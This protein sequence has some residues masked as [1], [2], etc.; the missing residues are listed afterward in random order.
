MTGQQP[1]VGRDE[2][3]VAHEALIRHW[4]RLRAW[5]ET[6]RADLLLRESVRE[7]AQAWE[8]HDRDESYLLHRGRRLEETAALRAHPR[9]ELNAQERAYLDASIALRERERLAAEKAR[10]A[11]ERLLMG[12]SAVA[13]FLATVAGWQGWAAVQE[14]NN[15]EVQRVAA[16]EAAGTAEAE[17]D[18]AQIVAS[19]LLA[20]RAGSQ[21]IAPDLALLLSV[22]ALRSAETYEAKKAL[23][24]E[25]LENGP[26][27]ATSRMQGDPVTS[28]AF[29]ADGS[30][31]VW[32][33]EDGR[34]FLWD[35]AGYPGRRPL[36]EGAVNQPVLAVAIHP[37]GNRIAWGGVDTFVHLW[38]L[39][40]GQEI[41]KEPFPAGVTSVAFDAGGTRLAAASE[42]GTAKVWK[43]SGNADPEK[44][45][46]V[47]VENR[48]KQLTFPSDGS[49]LL[50]AMDG[51]AATWQFDTDSKPM[52]H[53]LESRL[54][55]VGF[56][57]DA[58]PLA[59]GARE[60]SLVS[61]DLVDASSPVSES[62]PAHEGAVTALAIAS[63]GRT[64]ASGDARG[65]LFLTE[66]T[67][68]ETEA[69][70][71]YC[72]PAA[73]GGGSRPGT[74]NGGDSCSGI[75]TI[76]FASNSA[77]LAIG[78]RDG[79][80]ALCDLSGR[81]PLVL[82]QQDF[83]SPWLSQALSRNGEVLTV[84]RS[85]GSVELWSG[86]T[87]RW[88]SRTFG[89]LPSEISEVTLD[90]A[91]TM[92]GSVDERGKIV[93]W[94]LGS[95]S[96]ADIPLEGNLD[97]DVTSLAFSPAGTWFAAGDARGGISIWNHSV[98]PDQNFSLPAS[99]TKSISSLAFNPDGTLL[100]AGDD[101][102]TI[103]LWDLAT[104]PPTPLRVGSNH[105]QRV[106]GL[107]F[108]SDGTTMASGSTDGF[109]RLWDVATRRSFPELNVGQN[110]VSLA[111]SSDGKML[112]AGLEDSCVALWDVVARQLFGSLGLG[113]Q[114]GGDSQL[115][116]IASVAF[117]DDG[118]SLVTVTPEGSVTEW[119]T[120]HS[121]WIARA[122]RLAGRNLT[123]EDEQRAYM[124]S[125]QRQSPCPEFERTATA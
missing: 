17:R 8:Q 73:G 36:N 12:F 48:V 115:S 51:T 124:G 95:T 114:S 45:G 5:L 74:D 116:P 15:T 39:D 109:I 89:G 38:S 28:L 22:E 30:K 26:L 13:L 103:M 37:D 81:L 2:V 9:L 111:L 50:L 14:R 33:H 53:D 75:T 93:L 97:D 125:E 112:A 105:T 98:T 4:P 79:S 24:T 72:R 119:D 104:R 69:F 63:D 46:E 47:N 80:V 110:V 76:A 27:I 99:D 83:D 31:L 7:A 21:V 10:K 42:T 65:N 52:M 11:R 19:K 101:R 57:S 49:T 78:Y 82:D 121:S 35:I 56:T 77:M 41:W 67:S 16:D 106:T 91:G 58:R 108:S 18:R 71:R 6:D 62:Q 20:E 25:L 113:C 120:G 85:G 68:G 123:D 87:G 117:T 43:L 44:I 96:L 90:H 54:T 88:W 61:W 60:H 55:S 122:C 59:V 23:L 102:G 86:I 64:I 32:S 1:P 34:V 29:S 66:T 84:G 40:L 100:A 3:E 107:V 118:G 92:L 70:L 94:N